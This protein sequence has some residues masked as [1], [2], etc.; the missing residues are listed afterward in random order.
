MGTSIQETADPHLPDSVGG[1]ARDPA[2]DEDRDLRTI[3]GA[4]IGKRHGH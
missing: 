1:A 4:F 2:M 3:D